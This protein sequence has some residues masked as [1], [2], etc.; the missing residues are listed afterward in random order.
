M[1]DPA[2]GAPDLFGDL[3]IAVVA[4]GEISDLG[5]KVD[6]PVLPSRDVLDEAHHQAIRFSAAIT[7]AGISVAPKNR[8][9]SNRP[10]P[11]T[12]S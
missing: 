9:A 4:F 1:V 6:R 3:G 2:S 12:R 8:K 11:Q 10:S 5:H 7:T